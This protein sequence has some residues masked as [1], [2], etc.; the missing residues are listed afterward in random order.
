MGFH[1][2]RLKDPMRFLRHVQTSSL[3]LISPS[4]DR[5]ALSTSHRTVYVE[6]GLAQYVIPLFDHN[7]L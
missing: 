6:R 7:M 3:T 2:G 1:G 5:R 4:D